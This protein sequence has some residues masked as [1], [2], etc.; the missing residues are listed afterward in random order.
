MGRSL[1]FLHSA[2][3]QLLDGGHAGTRKLHHQ[4]QAL[5]RPVSR[6]AHLVDFFF[7]KRIAAFEPCCFRAQ[8]QSSSAR[9]IALAMLS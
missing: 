8:K 3:L 6:L 4:L 7:V 9:N 1:A 2:V 5:V